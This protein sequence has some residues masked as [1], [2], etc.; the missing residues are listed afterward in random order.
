MSLIIVKKSRKP[1]GIPTILISE[2]SELISFNTSFMQNPVLNG[3]KYV[4]VAYDPDERIIAFDFTS[5][6]NLKTD[7]HFKLGQKGMTSIKATSL[8]NSFNLKIK[9]IAGTYTGDALKGPESI[10]GFSENGFVIYIDKRSN[11]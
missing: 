11:S 8:L 7:E 6:E 2:K 3:A 5:E 9:D 10:E 4:R 1:V